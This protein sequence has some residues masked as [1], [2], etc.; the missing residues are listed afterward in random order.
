MLNP[1]LVTVIWEHVSLKFT[2][3]SPKQVCSDK[4]RAQQM[5]NRGAATLAAAAKFGTRFCRAHPSASADG[6]MLAI[7]KRSSEFVAYPWP[8]AGIAAA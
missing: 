8:P 1:R 4:L 7:K 2:R 5:M 6:L 3:N